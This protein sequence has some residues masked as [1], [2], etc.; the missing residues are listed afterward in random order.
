M[1]APT[2]LQ[3]TRFARATLREIL[4]TDTLL[5]NWRSGAGIPELVKDHADTPSHPSFSLRTA[6][7][8]GQRGWNWVESVTQW[9]SCQRSS[10]L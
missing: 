7:R 6:T 5:R 3:C 4:Y 8:I 1:S 10:R 2:E 9:H